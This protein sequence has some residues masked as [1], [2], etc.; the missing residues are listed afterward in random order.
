[1]FGIDIVGGGKQGEAKYQAGV[2]KRRDPNRAHLGGYSRRD[3]L[4]WGV[5]CGWG[6]LFLDRSGSGCERGPSRVCFGEGS[7][8]GGR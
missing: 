5:S 6:N 1:M 8:V 3:A 7:Q 2:T 4:S